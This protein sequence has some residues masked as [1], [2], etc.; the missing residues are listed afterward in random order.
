[1]AIISDNTCLT[2]FTNGICMSYPIH[3]NLVKW[4]TYIFVGISSKTASEYD[5]A[6]P[7]CQTAD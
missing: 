1:M 2:F 6:I 7:Q 5:Q 4:L 3:K